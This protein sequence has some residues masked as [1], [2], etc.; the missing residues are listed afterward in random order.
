MKIEKRIS[1]SHLLTLL[2]GRE[3]I[4]DFLMIINQRKNT[5][6]GWKMFYQKFGRVS[7]SVKKIEK[8]VC[9]KRKLS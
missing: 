4:I 6:C 3:S 7:R 1:T 9:S 2:L 5:G 8:L